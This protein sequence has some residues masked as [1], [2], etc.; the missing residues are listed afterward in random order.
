MIKSTQFTSL[1]FLYETQKY[2]TSFIS[3]HHTLT[4]TIREIIHKDKGTYC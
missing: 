2:Q 1:R 3:T 4:K